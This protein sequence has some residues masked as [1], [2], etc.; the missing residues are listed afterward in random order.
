MVHCIFKKKINKQIHILSVSTIPHQISFNTENP[1]YYTMTPQ[2]P[3]PCIIQHSTYPTHWPI[4]SVA[5][6]Q[7]W[8]WGEHLSHCGTNTISQYGCR[9]KIHQGCPIL[10]KYFPQNNHPHCSNLGHLGCRLAQTWN[11][12]RS[13][14]PCQT[15]NSPI[16]PAATQT[17]VRPAGVAIAVISE[18]PWRTEKSEKHQKQQ[19]KTKE[20]GH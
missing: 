12:C 18:W 15:S 8:S 16:A 10:Q 5:V 1:Q 11:C 20:K 13:R 3:P 2:V 9:G 14:H 17:T 19:R 6:W 7:H 4:S